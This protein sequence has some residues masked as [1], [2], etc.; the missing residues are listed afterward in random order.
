MCS[1][2]KIKEFKK[3][4]VDKFGFWKIRMWLMK[5]QSISIITFVAWEDIKNIKG[6]FPNNQELKFK[7]PHTLLMTRFR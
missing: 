1:G 5:N 2:I 7:F 6:S 4:V 3:K